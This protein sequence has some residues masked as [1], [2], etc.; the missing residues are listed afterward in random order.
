MPVDTLT[1]GRCTLRD[2]RGEAVL[3]ASAWVERP[4]VLV[5]LRHFG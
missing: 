2:A 1:L 5:W 4:A 3:V